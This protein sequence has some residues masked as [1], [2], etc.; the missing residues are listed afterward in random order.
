MTRLA[1]GNTDLI[2]HN[3]IHST[4]DRLCVC[5]QH[6]AISKCSTNACPAGRCARAPAGPS[7]SSNSCLRSRHRQGKTTPPAVNTMPEPKPL[8][9]PYFLRSD[10]GAQEHAGIGAAL[11]LELV[12]GLC[13]SYPI[14]GVFHLLDPSRS[15]VSAHGFS[16]LKEISTIL[17]LFLGVAVCR[18]SET[19]SYLGTSAHF[20]HSWG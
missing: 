4:Q 15:G 7:A 16:L 11:R 1:E 17:F 3:T 18:G 2:S 19:P 13:G 12:S 8:R 20:A 9:L 14:L 6:K 10:G 5:A